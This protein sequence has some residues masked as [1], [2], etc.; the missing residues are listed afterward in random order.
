[1]SNSSPKVQGFA[2]LN[3][4]GCVS[5]RTE[6]QPL[7]LARRTAAGLRPERTIDSAVLYNCY[8]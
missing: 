2:D 8:S 3:G 7:P 4:L 5:Q 6:W 1:M